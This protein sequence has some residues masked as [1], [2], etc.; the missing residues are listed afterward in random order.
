[1]AE[2][3]FCFSGLAV[4]SGTTFEVEFASGDNCVVNIFGRGSL[5]A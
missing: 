5:N 3:L 2:I 4:T 1:V